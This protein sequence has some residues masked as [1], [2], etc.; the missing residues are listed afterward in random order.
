LI[1]SMLKYAKSICESVY[2]QDLSK[3]LTYGQ[4]VYHIVA[5]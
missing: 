4:I 1:D 3:F 2:S 5:R